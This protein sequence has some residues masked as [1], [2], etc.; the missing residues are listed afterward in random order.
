MP[1]KTFRPDVPAGVTGWGAVGVL[2][3]GRIRALAM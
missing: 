1:Y 3:L 2:D